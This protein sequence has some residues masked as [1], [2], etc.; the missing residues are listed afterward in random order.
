MVSHALITYVPGSQILKKVWGPPV[1][2]QVILTEVV[3]LINLY[4]NPDCELLR[5]I[6]LHPQ[7]SP[8]GESEY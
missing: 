3:R 4:S 8:K 1:E 6:S 5:V 7:S 2:I